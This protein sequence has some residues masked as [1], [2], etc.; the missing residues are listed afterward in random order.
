MKLLTTLLLSLLTFS[1]LIAQPQ[2]GSWQ[3]A[4]KQGGVYNTTNLDNELVND[5][6]TDKYGNVYVT[7]IVNQSPHFGNVIYTAP[8]SSFGRDDAFVAK[9]DKCGNLKWAR[10]GGGIANDASTSI[11]VDDS[12][13]VYILGA[14]GSNYAFF[15]DS[16]HIDTI[17][18]GGVFWAKYDSVGNLKWVK[19]SSQSASVSESYPISLIPTHNGNLS[20]VLMMYPGAFYSGFNF[21]A[22]HYGRGLFEFDLNGNPVSVFPIDSMV[23]SASTLNDIFAFAY[24]SKGNVV[25]NFALYDTTHIFDTILN[26]TNSSTGRYLTA[27]VNPQTNKIKWIKEW[28]E[29]YYGSSLFGPV[30]IDKNDNIILDGSGGVGSVFNGDSIKFNSTAALDMEVCFKLDSNGNTLWHIVAD[31]TNS[32]NVLVYPEPITLYG[33]QYICAP[34]N[35]S[36]PTY[37]GGD[38]F[39]LPGSTYIITYINT[40]TGKV[41]FADTLSGSTTLNTTFQRIIS[42]EQGNVY[43]GGYF[44]SNLTAGNS[45]SITGGINDAFLLKWGLPCPDTDALI[46][47][48]SAERLVASVSG[49]HAID[50]TWQNVAQYADRYRVY[51][52]TTDSITGYV[53]IDSVNNT[54]THYTDV[55]VVSHQIYWYRVSAVNNA[56]ETFSN[57]DSAIIAPTG[58]DELSDIRHIALYPNPA[59]TYTKLSVWS[60]ATTPFSAT[61]SMTDIAGR[62]SYIKQAEIIQGKNDFIIDIS[63]LSAGVYVVNLHGDNGTYTKRLMVIK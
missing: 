44:T 24:D 30:L 22:T 13:S 41:E 19:A 34:I 14:L 23:S 60:D 21:T 17:S 7:G 25:Y 4:N 40:N 9:Y 18:N 55:N 49:I 59:N 35:V 57:S 1:T 26:K 39:N 6:C 47:P 8:F 16:N 5:I 58:I 15:P 31:N 27:K 12:L 43:G 56:G 52:S 42:D 61:I 33:D 45:V 29:D 32:S 48:L 62:E 54:T 51:R 3:W 38:T 37:W 36:G 2:L 11:H 10:F 53:L 63:E 28:K 50:V 46:P 20:T